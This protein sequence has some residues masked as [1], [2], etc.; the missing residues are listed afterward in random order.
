MGCGT[1]SFPSGD[2]AGHSLR[3]GFATQVARSGG[4]V[5]DIM[6]QT[7]HRSVQT[8]SRYVREGAD[9]SQ[10]ARREA[11]PVT[12]PVDEAVLGPI[13]AL[14]FASSRPLSVK[15][16][17]RLLDVTEDRISVLLDRLA[18][19]CAGSARGLQVVE[20]AK[21]WRVETKPQHAALVAKVRRG[22][23]ELP[24]SPQA[25]E[26]LAVV[27]L[28]QPVTTAEVTAIRGLDSVATLDTLHKRRLIG[29]V[30]TGQASRSP[31]QWRTT[32]GFLDA[33]GL[34]TLKDLFED[35]RIAGIFGR[36]LR[37]HRHR[38]KI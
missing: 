34:S 33:F 9:L 6:R 35:G 16:L 14:L 21:G 26:T 27:A 3:A 7:G 11:R 2:F 12:A 32:Q 37:G 17:A 22:K 4:T 5:F 20:V 23:G 19:A 25:L 38:R 15:L 36:R 8:A 24:L 29:T 28:R 1:P 30:A 10:L 31:A 13:E 18:D